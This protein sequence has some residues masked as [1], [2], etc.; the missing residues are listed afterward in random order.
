M[1]R[2]TDGCSHPAIHSDTP[3][4]DVLTETILDNYLGRD[5]CV[6]SPEV[7]QEK[8]TQ[9]ADAATDGQPFAR[10]VLLGLLECVNWPVVYARVHIGANDDA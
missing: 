4:E 2:T 6:E 9:D 3:M 5:L 1:P 7:L 10:S 8:I